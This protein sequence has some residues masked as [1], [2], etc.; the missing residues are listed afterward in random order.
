MA[1][2][3]MRPWG[4][5]GTSLS[6]KKMLI[7]GRITYTKTRGQHVS[8]D[9]LSTDHM[10]HMPMVSEPQ[11]GSQGPWDLQILDKPPLSSLQCQPPRTDFQC[12][13]SSSAH[14][15]LANNVIYA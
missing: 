10:A 6:D 15:C 14:Y 1:Y 11:N 5:L 7:R 4:S 3:H 2:E 9:L 8:K 12:L 13:S